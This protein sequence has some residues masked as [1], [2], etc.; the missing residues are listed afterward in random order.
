MLYIIKLMHFKHKAL[1]G[2]YGELSENSHPA[3]RPLKNVQF[4]SSSRKTKIL[5]V[6]IH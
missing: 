6:G 1:S 4:C 5:N 2:Q 3:A